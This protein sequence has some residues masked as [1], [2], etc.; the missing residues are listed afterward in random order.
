MHVCMCMCVSDHCVHLL[1]L[2]LSVHFYDSQEVCVC[3]TVVLLWRCT[4]CVYYSCAYLEVYSVCVLQLCFSGGVLCVL[5]LCFSGG[6]LSVLQLCFSGGVLC[7][8]IT[9]VLLWRCSLCIT[10]V[11]F[12][13]CTLGTTTAHSLVGMLLV[14]TGYI[15]HFDGD[16]SLSV[17]IC[18]HL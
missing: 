14:G 11:L 1:V 18:T 5:Q 7:V 10:V 16:I 8:C 13:R 6:V 3:I 17:Y 15:G 12:W 2:T 4:L 9:V